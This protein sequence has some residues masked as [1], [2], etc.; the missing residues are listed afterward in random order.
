V[1]AVLPHLPRKI[2]TIAKQ[3]AFSSESAKANPWRL[4][5]PQGPVVTREMGMLQQC[6]YKLPNAKAERLLGYTPP[7][8]FREGCRRSVGWLQFAG[9]PVEVET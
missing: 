2:K 5:R 9:Y 8:S 3:L 6:R 4:D 7:V 1:Q